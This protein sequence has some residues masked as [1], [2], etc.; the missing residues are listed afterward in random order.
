MVEHSGGRSLCFP[1]CVGIDVH[2]GSYIGVTQKLLH[3]LRCCAVSQQIGCES[4]SE[5][6]EMKLSQIM[7]V[8]KEN[9]GATRDTTREK[10]GTQ[11]RTGARENGKSTKER[12]MIYGTA[13]LYPNVKAAEC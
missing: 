2:G 7:A 4:M 8:A 5:Q 10:V 1:V 12:E 3:I 6:M 13:Q 9:G 11:A